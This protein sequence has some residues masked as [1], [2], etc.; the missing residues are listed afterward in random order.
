M[1]SDSDIQS[2]DDESL[3]LRMSLSETSWRDE[4][5]EAASSQQTIDSKL[6]AIE[7]DL[8]K[9]KDKVSRIETL[10]VE[11]H[12]VV[13]ER[14]KQTAER[15]QPYKL[16]VEGD[17]SII[18]IGDTQHAVPVDKRRFQRAIHL[19]P[20]GR[21]LLLK[22]LSMVIQPDELINFSY[23]GDRNME[24][25]LDSLADDDR[26]KAI[27]SQVRKS[28]PRFDAPMN[29]RRIRDAVNGKCRKLRRNEKSSSSS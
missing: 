23:K 8:N 10:L 28:F 14:S 26:F 22:L 18:M 9:M 15:G 4:D 17:E 16:A 21:A 27:Q 20:T 3:N 25:P 7:A 13:V 11:L 1:D 2:S 5:I 12:K 24:P 29:L 6:N 19:A